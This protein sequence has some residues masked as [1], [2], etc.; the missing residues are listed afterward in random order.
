MVKLINIQ[1]FL[2]VIDAVEKMLEKYDF[3]ISNR[4]KLIRYEEEDAQASLRPGPD[5]MLEVGKIL[6]KQEFCMEFWCCR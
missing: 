6:G 5:H 1:L 4:Y 3:R 2:V